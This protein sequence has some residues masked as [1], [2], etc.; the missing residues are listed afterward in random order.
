LL[1]YKVHLNKD[2]YMNLLLT[3]TDETYIV[4]FINVTHDMNNIEV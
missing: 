2:E 1:T 4:V 3:M